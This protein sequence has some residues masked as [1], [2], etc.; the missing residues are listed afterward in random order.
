MIG[1]I[2]V[3]IPEE[4]E[5][6]INLR[7]ILKKLGDPVPFIE[8]VDI[9]FDLI[10]QQTDFD[11]GCFACVIKPLSEAVEKLAVRIGIDSD[12]D[13]DDF[14]VFHDTLF[15]SIYTLTNELAEYYRP[16]LAHFPKESFGFVIAKRTLRDSVILNVF[17]SPAKDQPRYLP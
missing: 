14:I 12:G 4:N 16:Y 1:R 15:Q 6:V 13:D 9:A 10:L 11:D 17:L 2:I 7:G 8:F 3:P 5:A